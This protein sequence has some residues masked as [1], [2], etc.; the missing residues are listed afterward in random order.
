MKDRALQPAL[1][2]PPPPCIKGGKRRILDP[3]AF[4]HP[5]YDQFH[6]LTKAVAGRC[7]QQ[8]LHFM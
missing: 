3:V 1:F 7:G 2:M 5:Q 4:G 6:E 8:F